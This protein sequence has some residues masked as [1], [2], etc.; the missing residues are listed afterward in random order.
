VLAPWLTALYLPA[1]AHAGVFPN[2]LQA[3]H[4]S[5]WQLITGSGLP[6]DQPFRAGLHTVGTNALNA[7]LLIPSQLSVAAVLLVPIG[8]WTLRRDRVFVVCGLAP[9]A[10]VTATVATT[11]GSYAFWHLPLLAVCA[12]AAG[13]A[14]PALRV[15]ARR[16][17]RPAGAAIVVAAALTGAVGGIAY[18]SAHDADASSWARQVLAQLPPGAHVS[19]PWS[20]YAALRA[21]QELEHRRGD[22][23]IALGHHWPTTKAD[24][25][26]ARGDGYFVALDAGPTPIPTGLRVRAIGPPGRVQRKGMT[27]LSFLGHR[28]GDI[29]YRA[30]AYAVSG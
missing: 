20:A 17:L 4:T 10:A 29:Q 25:R 28:L 18:M 21:M 14:I 6:Y 9:A 27:G 13:C 30:Q 2:Q 15:G 26:R 1:R 22:L 8:V 12:I 7:A 3:G 16:T 23:T 11:N 24:V 19:A 5:W